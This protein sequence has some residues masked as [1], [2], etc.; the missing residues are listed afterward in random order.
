MVPGTF[1][2]MSAVQRAEGILDGGT[3]APVTDN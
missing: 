2:A 3:T 1:S